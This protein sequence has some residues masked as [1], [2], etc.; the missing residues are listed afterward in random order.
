MSELLLATSMVNAVRKTVITLLIAT[1]SFFLTTGNAQT[2]EVRKL[3]EEVAFEIK[4]QYGTP[5]R[6]AALVTRV[7]GP[8]SPD[9]A[10]AARYIMRSILFHDGVPDFAAKLIAPI[11]SPGVSANDLSVAVT[12]G[13]IQLQLSGI[14]RLDAQR[15]ASFV[16][17]TVDI[18]R[19]M[20]PEICKA[21]YLGQLSSE[22]S[23]AVE[24]RYLVQMPTPRFV[25][26]LNLYKEAI[27][28][29]LSGYP[30]VRVISR[31]QAMLAEKVYRGAAIK[32]AAARMSQQALQSIDQDP[33]SA[34][35]QDVC[36]FMVVILEGMLDIPEPYRSWQLARFAQNLK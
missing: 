1:G 28:A 16:R 9:K 12:E 14:S 35:A 32:R 19:M 36:D 5:E 24:R 33:Q 26:I 4:R 27:D 8:L 31:E 15:Q 13:M 7:Y 18:A 23:V 11:Y 17:Y 20:P 10:D 29:E 3:A 34:L 21:L 30:D 25:S 22:Q 6:L 2:V